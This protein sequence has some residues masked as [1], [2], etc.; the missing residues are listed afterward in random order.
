MAAFIRRVREIRDVAGLTGKITFQSFRHGGFT[1][2]AGDA[3][4]SDA[5]VNA[6]GAKTETTLDTAKAPW[7]S[8][9]GRSRVC[10]MRDQSRNVCPLAL[11]I[12]ST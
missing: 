9:A 8:D 7:T 3:G 10:W 1:A 11:L 6:V 5:D 4:R 2:A 12:L